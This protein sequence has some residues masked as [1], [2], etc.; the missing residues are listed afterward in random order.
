MLPNIN[1]NCG[2]KNIN[3]K[4]FTEKFIEPLGIIPF[5]ISR[6]EAT[7][8]FDN[9]IKQ[10][11]FHPNKLKTLSNIENLHGVYVPFW[12]FDAQVSA[13]WSGQAGYHYYETKNRVVNGKVQTIRVQKT[14]W[15]PLFG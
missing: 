9:W 14:R 7:R 4:S 1:V 2:S 8:K 12:T 10:G 15:Q 6:A 11:L 5:Y 13:N 3:E